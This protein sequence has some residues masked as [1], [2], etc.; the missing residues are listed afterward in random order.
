MRLRAESKLPIAL[1]LV[2]KPCDEEYASSRQLRW[3]GT[4]PAAAGTPSGPFSRKQYCQSTHD[5][6][7]QVFQQHLA[8]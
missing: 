5:A 7:F 1:D 6:V 3:C 8:I 2:T 4:P